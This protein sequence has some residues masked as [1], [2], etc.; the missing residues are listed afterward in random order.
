MGPGFSSRLPLSSPCP[1]L[2][3]PLSSPWPLTVALAPP[4]QLKNAMV[5]ESDDFVIQF[6]LQTIKNLSFGAKIHF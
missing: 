6:M 1:P 5:L 4:Q 3:F 2:V